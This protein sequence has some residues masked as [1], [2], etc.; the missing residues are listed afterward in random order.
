MIQMHRIAKPALAFL[1]I[2][3]F[4]FAQ[5]PANLLQQARALF[6]SGHGR[7]SDKIIPLLR[8]ANA[9]WEQSSSKDPQ[10]A[11]SLDLLALLLRNK[12]RDLDAWRI[13]AAGVEQGARLP[14][15]ASSP[16]SPAD[17]PASPISR[18]AG[19]SVRL[20]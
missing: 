11:E 10:Y 18:L 12:Q 20:S 19:E 6:A 2:P 13:E 3:F 4:V 15:N 5:D 1:F 17:D 14:G 16:A 9:S 8:K 7:V